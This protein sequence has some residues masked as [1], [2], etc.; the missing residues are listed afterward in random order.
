MW[1]SFRVNMYCAC[2]VIKINSKIDVEIQLK[3]EEV[4]HRVLFG[5]ADTDSLY[6]GL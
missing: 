2:F 4:H 6:F 3:T 5:P 1:A